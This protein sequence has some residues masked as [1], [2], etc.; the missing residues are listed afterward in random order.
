MYRTALLIDE[1]A[2]GMESE[3]LIPL[4]VVAPPEEYT[5]EMPIFA[6]AGDEKQLGPRPISRLPMLEMSL[7]ERLF[8]RPLYDNHPLS[9]KAFAKFGSG[10]TPEEISKASERFLVSTLTLGGKRIC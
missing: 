10:S 5:T 3:A 7:I 1:A 8:T 2:Q 9:R 4:S 6:M